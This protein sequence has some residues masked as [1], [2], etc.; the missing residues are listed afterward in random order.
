MIRNGD[1][2]EFCSFVFNSTAPNRYE[3]VLELSKY[4]KVD[5]YE[6]YANVLC[7]N[8]LAR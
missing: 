8:T 6:E 7:G 2:N 5:C 1:H 3:M 4:K